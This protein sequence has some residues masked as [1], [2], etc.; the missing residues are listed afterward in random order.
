LVRLNFCKH[1]SLPPPPLQPSHGMPPTHAFP[2]EIC[3]ARTFST[4]TK[5][6]SLPPSPRLPPQ[7][8]QSLTIS[9]SSH[10]SFSS[11]R[12][13][14]TAIFK[15]DICIFD[16]VNNSRES[17]TLQLFNDC[18]ESKTWL[19]FAKAKYNHVLVD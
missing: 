10:L 12:C 14:C 18:E 5:S 11:P 16:S 4:R 3:T 1:C 13:K 2:Q 15:R 8:P 9:P 7:F 6:L 19:G 17:S